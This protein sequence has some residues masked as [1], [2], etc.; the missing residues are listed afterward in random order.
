M[1]SLVLALGIHISFFMLSPRESQEK[2]VRPLTTKFVKREPRLVKP[3]ELRK[4]PKP[5]PRP[6]RRKMITVKAKVSRR[7]V[8]AS[9]QPMRVLDSLARPKGG[10]SRGISFEAVKL[11]PQF[12]AALIIGDKEPDE[13]IDMNLEMLDIDALDTGKYHAMVIQNPTDKKK[14]EGYFHMYV[15]Y[16]E[17]SATHQLAGIYFERPT[18]LPN[19]VRA[20]NNYTGIRA[21]YEGRLLFTN[22]EIFKVPWLYT[23]VDA[24]RPGPFKITDAEALNLGKYML[25]GGFFFCEDAWPDPNGPS[26]QTARRMIRDALAAVGK[27]KGIDWNYEKLPNDHPIYH[28]YFDFSGPPGGLDTFMHI[29]GLPSPYLEGIH[30]D[31]RLV[32]IMSNKD[33]EDMWATPDI[34]EWW[35]KP[36]ITRQFQFGVNLVIFALIQEGSITQQVMSHVQ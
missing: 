25:S 20:I 7:E 36:D 23:S 4:R 17:K 8:S 26:N 31:G 12:G 19:L 32:C 10:V 33:Y 11:E 14:I 35:G 1:A 24:H 22:K 16:S 21:T 29:P 30:F 27:K 5:K 3:L 18:A 28:C 9:P 6:M 15:G 34:N 2:A 13:R